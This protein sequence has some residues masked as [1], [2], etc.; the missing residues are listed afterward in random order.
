MQL[1]LQL[2]QLPLEGGGVLLLLPHQ[3]LLLG[4]LVRRRVWLRVRVGARARARA[5]VRV[6]A[7]VSS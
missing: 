5:V 2:L 1:L 4:N 6:R 3:A 7:V